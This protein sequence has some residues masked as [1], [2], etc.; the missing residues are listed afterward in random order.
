MRTNGSTEKF[1]DSYKGTAM[2]DKDNGSGDLPLVEEQS[3]L[4]PGESLIMRR[5]VEMEGRLQKVETPQN[6]GDSE[7]STE[8][9]TQVNSSETPVMMET[10][11]GF[12]YF[13]PEEYAGPICEHCRM[14]P[15]PYCEEGVVGVDP[16]SHKVQT[17]PGGEKSAYLA[18]PQKT[19]W[20]N[21]LE[22]LPKFSPAE[23][24]LPPPRPVVSRLADLENHGNDEEE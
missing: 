20:R 16:A 12:L 8:P 22:P 6:Q 18:C 15:L 1:E 19:R 10:D 24:P 13:A 4:T 14:P 5:L 21:E 9:K 7:G 2:E 3:A 23:K 11:D 17:D